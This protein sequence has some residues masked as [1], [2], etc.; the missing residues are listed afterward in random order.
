MLNSF[1]VLVL[2]WLISLISQ[3]SI[4]QP[5]A[6]PKIPSLLSLLGYF[7]SFFFLCCFL[8]FLFF[9]ILLLLS[10]WTL[11]CKTTLQ[12]LDFR[13]ATW[14]VQIRKPHAPAI[15]HLI[16]QLDSSKEFKNHCDH[17]WEHRAKSWSEM[18]ASL[19]RLLFLMGMSD[20]PT[21]SSR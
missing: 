20:L 17:V 8:F 6:T 7:W 15:L 10:K 5:A 18:T 14:Q 19:R 11:S 16:L 9:F 3:C 2:A 12:N 21:R 4:V 13:Q 1:A